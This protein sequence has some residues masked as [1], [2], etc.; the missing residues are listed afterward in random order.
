MNVCRACTLNLPNDDMV[1]LFSPLPDSVS[2]AQVLINC[3][4]VKIVEGEKLPTML[5]R[6][7][8]E[9][10]KE[11]HQFVR[12]VQESD[13]QLRKAQVKEFSQP[14]RTDSEDDANLDH[15]KE[16]DDESQAASVYFVL[17]G[18]ADDQFVQQFDDATALEEIYVSE[19]RSQASSLTKATSNSD[20]SSEE[21]MNDSEDRCNL[22]VPVQRLKIK[23]QFVCCGCLKT[24]NTESEIRSHS[25]QTHATKRRVMNSA[26]NH[27]CGTCYKRYLTLNALQQH[28]KKMS[29]VKHIY[30]CLHCRKRYTESSKAKQHALERHTKSTTRP[31]I[32]CAQACGKSFENEELLLRHSH[33]VHRI[34]KIEFSLPDSQKKPIECY[35]C[36]KRFETEVSLLRHQQ[37][38]YK[39]LFYQCVACG[40]KFRGSEALAIHERS[41]RNEKPF[42]CETCHKTFASKTILKT[43][44]L[45]HSDERPFICETCGCGFRR[46]YNLQVHVLSHTDTQPFPC[47]LC[48]ARFKAK[49]HLN[50]H[51][52]TH[53]GEKPYRCRHCEKT[54]ADHTNRGRHEMSHTGIKPYE[55][56][57]CS[58][59]FTRKWILVKHEAK[60]SDV[61][62]DGMDDFSQNMYALG[63]NS[64]MMEESSEDKLL[65]Q[66]ALLPT[67]GQEQ[68]LPEGFLEILNSTAHP[69]GP[70][71]APKSCCGC[72][73][74]FQTEIALQEHSLAAHYSN[75][76]I[77]NAKPYECSICY[78]RFTDE[79]SLILHGN[80]RSLCHRCRFCEKRFND[81]KQLQFHEKY[82]RRKYV[83]KDETH[84]CDFC[85][86]SFRF[87]SSLKAHAQ[88]HTIDAT[89]RLYKCSQCER[90][91]LRRTHLRSHEISHSDETPF[92]C[93]L[94]SLKFKRKQHLTAHL[95]IHEGNDKA[96]KCRHCGVSFMHQSTRAY[97]E[98]SKHTGNYPF[99][100]NL[101]G[102]NFFR[103]PLYD[104]HI[105]RHNPA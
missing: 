52:R 1:S 96:Y 22:D 26:K 20:D 77:C 41:H 18:H 13:R 58:K 79:S 102:R 5:C 101:C 74:S 85:G 3:A 86:R 73:L 31:K 54:F 105:A 21:D 80:T 84:L 100:C 89:D 69:Q 81:R 28:V 44:Q 70:E 46:K 94:C 30:E 59:T 68:I 10:I 14:V 35:V 53:T 19:C 6:E 67:T 61:G 15:G 37:R 11:I 76:V 62:F 36:F 40:L 63:A 24:F 97:H 39:P 91:F 51:M 93:G 88:L 45:T 25:M 16:S 42:R 66:T 78:K 32:C 90:R 82:H 57:Q 49:T 23:E 65:L 71:D 50:Y 27:I 56:S 34:N 2:M 12:K 29:Q 103:K 7:C 60:H 99:S 38:I 75:R 72:E 64:M 98:V 104:K 55:C 9:T 33:S 83:T 8:A 92:G 95:K 48:P 17:D 4:D 43:H 87:R 47:D